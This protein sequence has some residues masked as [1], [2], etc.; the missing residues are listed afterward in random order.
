MVLQAR[1]EPASR[2]SP[3]NHPEI[4]TE[5]GIMEAVPALRAKGF[6]FVKLEDISLNKPIYT[7]RG[8]FMEKTNEHEANNYSETQQDNLRKEI[9]ELESKLSVLKDCAQATQ[10][11]LDGILLKQIEIMAVF[12]VVISVIITN[13]VGIDAFGNIGIKG[14]ARINIAL[15]IAVFILLLGIKLFI[16][17]FNKKK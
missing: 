17:G 6:K 11:K 16:L 14:L 2:Q 4:E 5:E 8:F 12:I 10:N 15:V 13:I 7:R 3:V 9:A 1:K